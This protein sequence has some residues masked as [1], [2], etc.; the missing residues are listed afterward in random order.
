MIRKDK[1]KQCLHALNGI[2][3]QLRTCAFQGENS[4]KIGKVLD[5]VEELP[6]F[7][8]SSGDKTK[9]YE[10]SLRNLAEKYPEFGIGLERFLREQAPKE[11]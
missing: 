11:W 2:L 8:A 3:V 4:S 10:E 7:L 6:R 9:A 1:S 5:I